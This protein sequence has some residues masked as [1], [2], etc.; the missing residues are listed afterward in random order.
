MM[1]TH[2]AGMENMYQLVD[3]VADATLEELTQ[4]LWEDFDPQRAALSVISPAR[5]G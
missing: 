3:W 4:R 1:Q 2:F 5:E